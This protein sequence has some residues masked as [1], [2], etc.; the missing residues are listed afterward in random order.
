ME[1][2]EDGVGRGGQD[3]GAA[4][5]GVVDVE[6]GRVRGAADFGDVGRRAVADVVPVDAA[7]PRV[8]LY[9]VGEICGSS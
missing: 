7:E 2:A 6:V 1:G 3:V 5:V 8:T 4:E 9:V